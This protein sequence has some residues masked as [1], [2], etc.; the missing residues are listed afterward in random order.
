MSERSQTTIEQ[1]L[2]LGVFLLALALRV[3]QLGGV[4]LNEAEAGQALRAYDLA[5]G[6]AVSVG[7]QASYVLLTWLN[8]AI[9]GS[10]AFLARMW[11]ALLGAGIV[12][13]P[14][15]V[16]AQLGQKAALVLAT[17]LALSP[18][19]VAFSRTASSTVLAVLFLMLA[20]MAWQQGKGR[21]TGVFVALTLLSGAG[22]YIGLLGIYLSWLLLPRDIKDKYKSTL[23]SSKISAK[24]VLLSF[25]LSLLLGATAFLRIPQAVSGIGAGLAEFLSRWT[26]P[27]GIQIVTMLLA[28]VT[29][30]LPILIIGLVAGV[31]AWVWRDGVGQ[32]MSVWAIV[33]LLVA[34]INPGREISD[35]LWVLIPVWALAAM[36]I[37][38][39]LE[40]PK[41]NVSSVFGTVFL[42]VIL[43][44]FLWIN[45][46]AMARLT[47]GEGD[48]TVRLTVSAALVP[49]AALAL[50]L[51]GYGWSRQVAVQGLAWSFVLLS[52]ALYISM[53]VRIIQP[54]ERS[55]NELWPSS[56]GA[57][58]VSLLVDSAADLSGWQIG[59]RKEIEVALLSESAALHWAFRDW[60]AARNE[61]AL[62]EVEEP[63]MIAA[64][65]LSF[66]PEQSSAYRGQSFVWSREINWENGFPTNFFAWF[67]FREA[68]TV[69][70]TMTLWVRSDLFPPVDNENTL[71]EQDVIDGIIE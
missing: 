31:R 66:Q 71:S 26:L 27:G 58:Q 33:A 23:K 51:I 16:R 43:A 7:S 3:S 21:W 5:E 47:P 14:Y 18:G 24:D 36:G 55:A 53:D 38:H 22:S 56:S 34:I 8:F 19:F 62:T 17:G 20:I 48:F 9:L 65:G 39:Y 60:P 59:Q 67:V 29:Y 25:G 41:T 15:A 52:V 57:G 13:L 32:A 68:A 6:Q 2:Y 10:S 45:A 69:S 61:I 49:L 50:T 28:L 4:A 63:A 46:S 12:L 64:Q 1:I 35:L 40:K 44:S 11:P 42:V 70:E 54:G 30:S 37:S